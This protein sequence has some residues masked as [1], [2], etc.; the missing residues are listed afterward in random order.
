MNKQSKRNLGA[1]ITG[2]I[3]SGALLGTTTA[4]ATEMFN[5][6][7][8]GS[9]AELR[10]DLLNASNTGFKSPEAKC[11]EGKCGDEKAET[12]SADHK[13]GEGKCGEEK[14]NAKEES[15]EA[16]ASDHK[17]GEGK[18]GDAKTES[19]DKMEEKKNPDADPK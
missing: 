9:G 14:A 18:C 6:D 10:S 16:K 19:G 4:N 15:S 8:L 5:Y 1:I 17:C 3:M 7:D 11:G 2:T 13:C 12:K